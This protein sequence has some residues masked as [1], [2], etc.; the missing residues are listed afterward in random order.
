MGP[1][2]LQDIATYQW[3]MTSDSLNFDGTWIAW[4]QL[5]NF[6]ISVRLRALY[7]ELIPN[8]I[9]NTNFTTTFLM[10][11][12]HNIKVEL[13]SPK[14]HRAKKRSFD[15]K[16]ISVAFDKKN[17]VVIKDALS[18]TSQK[19]PSSAKGPK[20]KSDEA[21]RSTR[22]LYT[23]VQS[24][25]QEKDKKHE[26]RLR[27]QNRVSMLKKE[28][29][30][31]LRDHARKESKEEQLEMMHREQ[32]ATRKVLDQIKIRREKQIMKNRRKFK[33]RKEMAK[34]Q[35][36]KKLD[37]ALAYKKQLA[38][39]AR[40]QS[41]VRERVSKKAAEREYFRKVKLRSKVLESKRNLGYKKQQY[42][43]NMLDT[44]SSEYTMQMERAQ[45]EIEKED[46]ETE[47]LSHQVDALAEML[48]AMHTTG[49]LPQTMQVEALVDMNENDAD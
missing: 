32:E 11:S 7:L 36:Q 19:R 39:N 15:P 41:Q 43:N 6:A 20:S 1:I 14:T 22:Q 23:K 18:C 4:R 48:E 24:L 28:L 27:L 34:I 37:D 12:K 44:L 5:M 9:P 2:C 21:R 25:Q 30:R 46:K 35:K 3:I 42:V 29:Q 31:A 45:K 47:G 13:P 40:L 38:K 49:K 16:T 17:N 33:K 26:Q 10:D 8:I